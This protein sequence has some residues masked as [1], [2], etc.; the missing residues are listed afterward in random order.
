MYGNV[1][2]FQVVDQTIVFTINKEGVKEVL[3]TQNF[4]KVPGIYENVGFPY[5]ERFLGNGLIT[6]TNKNRWKQRRAKINPS[7]HKK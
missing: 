4:P 2:K 7:F 6:D 1:F 5:R 3:V